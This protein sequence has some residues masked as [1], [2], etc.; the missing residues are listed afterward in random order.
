MLAA[1]HGRRQPGG[2]VPDAADAA[3]GNAVRRRHIR[4][5]GLAPQQACWAIGMAA[6]K[7]LVGARRSAPDLRGMATENPNARFDPLALA[8]RL[9]LPLAENMLTQDRTHTPSR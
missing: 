3:P 2:T 8:S 4:A 7:Q 6:R 5:R 9:N 1:G